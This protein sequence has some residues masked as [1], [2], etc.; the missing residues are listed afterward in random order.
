LIDLQPV[1]L[2]LQQVR[3]CRTPCRNRLST[4]TPA[5]H[6]LQLVQNI[7]GVR[8]QHVLGDPDLQPFRSREPFI[9]VLDHMP[10]FSA[11]TAAAIN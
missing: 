7:L 5:P 9:R 6:P 3:N 1:H 4:R 8:H 11:G 2:I 10:D